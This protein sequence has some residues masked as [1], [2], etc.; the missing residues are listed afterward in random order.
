MA[1]PANTAFDTA[2]ALLGI[3][4]CIGAL[5][6]TVFAIASPVPLPYAGAIGFGG[7]VLIING[8]THFVNINRANP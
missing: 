1:S 5:A 6:C 8:I 7:G 4:S 2:G 3:A